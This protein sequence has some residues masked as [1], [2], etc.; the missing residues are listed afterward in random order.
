MDPIATYHE[1]L[2]QVGRR[3]ELYP[4]RIVIRARW[5]W[6]GTFENTVPLAKLDP[7]YRSFHIRNKWF[8][9][10]MLVLSVGIAIALL[11]GDLDALRALEPLPVLGVTVAL[12]G[13]ALSWLTV[14]RIRFVHFPARDGGKGLDIGCAGR[15]KAQFDAFVK[16][17]QRRIRKSGGV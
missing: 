11:S 3:F 17:V 10:S 13:L 15:E 1:R 7:R 5:L 8:K 2:L 6:R 9:P 14:R 4:D 16:E 12:V